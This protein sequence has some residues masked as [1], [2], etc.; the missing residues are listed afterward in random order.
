MYVCSNQV[1]SIKERFLKDD[2]HRVFL[3]TDEKCAGL[4]EALR[5]V[6]VFSYIYAAES[7]ESVKVH[8]YYLLMYIEVF[9]ATHQLQIHDMESILSPQVPHNLSKL[10]NIALTVS[11]LISIIF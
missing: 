9:L 11:T 3:L 5:L 10:K 8:K 6:F 1:F 2:T 4:Q 7:R